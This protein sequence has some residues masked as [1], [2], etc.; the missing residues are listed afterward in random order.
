MQSLEALEQLAALAT[1]T[2]AAGVLQDANSLIERVREGRFYLACLGQ[3]KRG[4]STLLNA[5]I[6]DDVLPTGVPPVTSAVTVIRFGKRRARIR[7]A[8]GVW[9]DVAINRINEYVAEHANPQNAKGVTGVEV[10]CESPLLARGLCLVDTPGIGSVFAANTEETRSFVPHIDAALAVLG[11]DP[12]ISGAELELI[13][14]VSKQV[15]D[16]LFVL[17][18]VDRLSDDESRES[19]AFTET[20]LNQHRASTAGRVFEVSALERLHRRGPERDWPA[21]VRQIQVLAESAGTKLVEF[22]A[23]RGL[24]SLKGRLEA[25]LIEEREALLRPIEASEH[26]LSELRR[27]AEEAKQA[28]LELGYLFNAEHRKLAL[29]WDSARSQFVNEAFASITGNLDERLAESKARCGP[30]LRALVFDAAQDLTEAAVRAWL[31]EQCPI[32]EREFVSVTERFVKHAN[33]FIERLRA[34]G[35]FAPGLLPPEL[36]DE[37]GL[38]ARSRFF[39]RSLMQLTTPPFWISLVDCFRRVESARRAARLAGREYS[40]LLLEKNAN[41]VLGDFDERV[42]ESRRSVESALKRTLEEVVS[43]AERAAERARTVQAQGKNA[44]KAAIDDV[45]SRLCALQSLEVSAPKI[46]A[47]SELSV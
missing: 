11:G 17:N 27:C 13:E 37:T 22:A 32:V 39:Y 34:A 23:R 31:V 33:S 1:A 20:I 43:T 45:N 47:I 29:R 24:A 10:F 7:F 38:R 5:L 19:R 35:D 12:P 2:G 16:I 36:S 3:F 21:L 46:A 4:K 44:I 18:K 8:D 25:T 15:R 42:V 14:A 41:R 30:K 6:G 9:L 28:S 26:R 40:E